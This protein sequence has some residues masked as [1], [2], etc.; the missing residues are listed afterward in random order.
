MAKMTKYRLERLKEQREKLNARI[1]AVEAREKSKERKIDVRKKIL[2]GAYYL[3]Q[4]EKN[5][6]M[7]EIVNLMDKFLKR[8]FDR[9]IFG[10]PA[11]PNA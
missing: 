3:D 7:A 1:Q 2:I 5:N 9:D 4:A 10:L 6:S 11:L 8:D